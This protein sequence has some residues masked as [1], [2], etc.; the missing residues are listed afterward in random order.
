[1]KRIKN[2][3]RRPMMNTEILATEVVTLQNQVKALQK[4]LG[5][6]QDIEEIKNLQRAYGFYLEH[7][8]FQEIVDCFS[9]SPEVVFDLYPVGIWKGKKGVINYFGQRKEYDPQFLHQTMQLSPI[10]HVDADGRI[11]KGRWYGY[12]PI[13]DPNNKTAVEL[14]NSGT[15]E[16]EYIKEDGIWKIKTLAWRV[17]YASKPGEGLA[18][19]KRES[20]FSKDFKFYGSP[21]DVVTEGKS[22]AYPSGYIYPFHYKHPVTGRKTSEDETNSKLGLNIGQ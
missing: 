8:M 6:L 17:N 3:I 22:T 15:Y 19:F 9:D 7:W 11:A 4:Q 16:M 20:V 5:T 18:E 1:M 10:I 12:G 14:L 2:F 13:V 21:P